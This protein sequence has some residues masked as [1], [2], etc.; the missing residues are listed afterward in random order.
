MA[1][2]T[3]TGQSGGM[4]KSKHASLHG[5]G[6]GPG[7]DGFYD[8]LR[9]P[10]VMRASSGRWFAGVSAGIARW[11]GVD[12]LVVRAAFILF[13]IFFGMGL[14]LYLV[15]WLLMPDERGEIH[16]ERALKHGDGGSIVLLVVTVISVLGG[17]PWWGNDLHGLRVGGLVLLAIGTWWFV[18][19]TDTG[20]EL[21][22]WPWKGSGSG[23]T[24]PGGHDAGRVMDPGSTPRQDDGAYEPGSPSAPAGASTGNAA[25]NAG[26]AMSAGP[27]QPVAPPLPRAPRPRT[28]SIGFAV[29]LLVLGAAVVA[30]AV[31]SG[32][33]RTQAWPANPVALGL[34]TGLG[35]L[36]L[37]ILAAGIAGRRAG[38]LAF[39]A[40]VG[41]MATLFASAAPQGLTQPWQ[42]GQRNYAVTSLT[43]AP[44]LQLGLGEMRVDLT[45][46]D[47]KATPG[48]DTVTATVGMGQINLVV[49]KDVHVVVN[50]KARAG[51]LVATGTT[52]GDVNVNSG[53]DGG[54]PVR[55]GSNGGISVA[56]TVTYG[57]TSGQAE[58]V[59]NAEVGL[60]EIRVTTGTAP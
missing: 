23:P 4:T 55:V 8:A 60:G 36:G 19:R 57:T 12:A 22:G 31:V 26:A 7:L 16:L 43:P 47:W 11:L 15:L 20:R 58:I 56:Q 5:H 38:G 35:I 49:P 40:V 48:T 28:P 25:A 24:A 6:H 52:E 13:S 27:G 44:D 37:G 59:V 45:G 42:A 14:A 10:G 33:A 17:G 54:P 3:P 18:T 34:A 39:F 2:G 50:A 32:L 21:T 30:G 51:A 1:G 53:N 29:G 46:A 9:R 41:I